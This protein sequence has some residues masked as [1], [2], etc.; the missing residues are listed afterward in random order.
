M[1]L[2]SFVLAAL[3]VVLGGLGGITR[4]QYAPMGGPGGPYAMAGGGY[5]PSPGMPGPSP[6]APPA[7]A[8]ASYAGIGGPAPMGPMSAPP[9]MAPMSMGPMM[10]P[11]GSSPG[12]EIGP[13]GGGGDYCPPG[14]GP[15]GWTNHYFAFGE[16]LYLQPRGAE[17]AYAVPISSA[18]AAGGTAV[19]Q[20]N[21]RVA[22]LDYAP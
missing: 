10:G 11:M 21:V 12:M 6:Y 7:F 9:S 1:R 22:D 13:G 3:M 17:V 14:Y 5:M 18:A 8:P 15:D 4:A 20:G 16:F 19:Q 2:R